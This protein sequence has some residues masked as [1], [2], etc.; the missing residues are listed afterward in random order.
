MSERTIDQIQKELNEAID[1]NSPKTK[2]LVEELVART[3]EHTATMESLKAKEN[4]E[5]IIKID[6]LKSLLND[7]PE[8]TDETAEITLK[9]SRKQLKDSID[10]YIQGVKN[11]NQEEVKKLQ[12]EVKAAKD[13]YET[14]KYYFL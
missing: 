2:E 1:S 7:K 3:K 13:K 8:T 4:Q 10:Q 12:D 11:T 6:D 9:A 14:A 5:K